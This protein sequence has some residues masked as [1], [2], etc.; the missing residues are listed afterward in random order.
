MGYR[1][2]VAEKEKLSAGG[3]IWRV[4]MVVVA[5]WLVYWMVRAYVL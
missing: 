3:V 1:K 2:S 4:V 5:L